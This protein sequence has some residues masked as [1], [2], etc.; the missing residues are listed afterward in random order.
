MKLVY[1]QVEVEQI[2]ESLNADDQSL[3]IV[4]FCN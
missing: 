1:V 3:K 4:Q 2:V